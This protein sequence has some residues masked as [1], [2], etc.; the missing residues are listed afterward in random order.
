MLLLAVLNYA[1]GQI[2]DWKTI[3][4]MVGVTNSTDGIGTAVRFKRV[5]IINETLYE[6]RTP[7]FD[8]IV[9][10][11][12]LIYFE[13]PL[14]HP[15]SLTVDAS[16]NAFV[17]DTFNQLIRKLTPVG[18]NWTSSTIGGGSFSQGITVGPDGSV[19]LTDSASRLR[20]VSLIGSN[21]VMT[22]IAGGGYGGADGNNSAAQFAG[23][24]GTE[25]GGKIVEHL[26]PV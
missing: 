12:C 3:A 8:V 15:Y 2:Y 17:A 6:A 23:P 22:T 11:Q 10:S 4:G 7:S 25:A 14:N 24:E 26:L 1:S 21:W 19:Y 5:V 13:H 16:G 9:N 20:R 18:A